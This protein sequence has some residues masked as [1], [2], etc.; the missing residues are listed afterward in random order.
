MK[1]TS[2][3]IVM[4]SILSAAVISLTAV[5]AGAADYGGGASPT[6]T[7]P[8]NVAGSDA[9]SSEEKATTVLTDTAVSSAI[10]DAAKS[11]SDSVTVYMKEDA[12]GK[13]T[14]QETAIAEIAKND[15]TVTI[16]VKSDSNS[17]TDYSVVIDPKLITEAK[18]IDLGMD[19]K[20]NTPEGMKESGV[21]IPENSIVIAPHQKGDFGMTI[22]VNLPA[23]ALSGINKSTASVYYISDSGEIT[24]LS[25]ALTFNADGSASIAISHASEYVISDSD[26]T[27][28]ADTSFIDGAAEDDEEAVVLYDD[29][30]GEEEDDAAFI[31]DDLVDDDNPGTGAG[32]ALGALAV[33]AAATVLA[34][35]RK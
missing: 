16:E 25:N 24:K 23:A 35:K 26:M 11:G 19:I 12:N 34:K 22:S 29:D 18:A 32:L 1:K 10:T 9:G 7:A 13:V 8:T 33:S 3:R 2:A 27:G 31:D 17:D 15:V 28:E 5:S 14:V 4:T 30:D 6:V 20:V 21:D